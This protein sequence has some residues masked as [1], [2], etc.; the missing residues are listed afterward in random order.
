MKRT[1]DLNA[2]M[3]EYVNDTQRSVEAALAELVSSC[4][5]ACG[6]HAGDSDTM[7]TTV[8]LAKRH[9]L[10]V[11]AHPSYPDREGFGRRSISIT[12]GKLEESL[13]A[14]ISALCNILDT[15][16]MPL[17]HVK[18]HGALYNDAAKTPALANTIVGVIKRL[19]TNIA[20]IG[21]PDSALEKAAQTMSISFIAEGFV[22]RLYRSDGS[23]TPRNQPGAVIADINTR[24]SQ[25]LALAHSEQLNAA[26]G[27]LKISVQTLCIHSDS[28]G[29]VETAGA[30][31]K[32][33]ER[34]G[35]SIEAQR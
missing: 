13:Y 27:R 29:A 10:A 17:R 18:P 3:G 19:N 12:P 15:E 26:D 25:A 31:R 9:G 11:G 7:L 30:I 21:P 35:F 32:T 22:D 14:Q 8:S 24:A 4:S 23:L 1:I 34:N 6:G 5:I 16:S 20:L 33:L 2:D 28:P